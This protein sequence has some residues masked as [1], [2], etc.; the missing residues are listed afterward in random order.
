MAV[1]FIGLLVVLW[2][3]DLHNIV[4]TKMRIDNAGD[5]AALSAARWQGITLNMVGEVNLIQAAL[6]CDKLT[7]L[8]DPL[9]SND[10]QQLQMDVE[11]VADLRSRLSLN[12]PLMGYIAAQ[13][14]AF[15]NLKEKDD[16]NR[17]QD[18][19]SW[20]AERA[21]DFQ[22]AGAYFGGTVE[23]PYDGAWE[24]Y[25]NLLASIAGNKMVAECANPEFFLYY[26]TGDHILLDP[27]FYQ[28][29]AAGQWCYFKDGEARSLIESYE[30]YSDWAP[31]PP[32]RNRPAVNSE[33]FGLDLYERTASLNAVAR[34]MESALTNHYADLDTGDWP[35][36]GQMA[37]HFQNELTTN[38]TVDVSRLGD[39]LSIDFPWHVY[40]TGKWLGSP[41]PT[42][43]D[44][45]FEE[46]QQILPE[47]D[48]R[49]ADAVVDCYINAENITPNMQVDSDWIYWH[50]AAKPFGYLEDPDQSG[51]R[52]TP[53]YFGV[54]LPA[55]DD[56]RLIHTDLSSSPF[57]MIPPGVYEHF[58]KHLPEY[59]QNGLSGI[60][61]NT[62]W[63]CRMLR[64]WEDASFREEGVRWLEQH[65]QE[66]DSGKAC[67][68]PPPSYHGG[69][70]SS[71][72]AM[73]RG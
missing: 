46:G 67:A 22:T 66:I 68:P 65:Q 45:P 54:V 31:L 14:A 20:L 47:Y 2:N 52:R 11:E 44:F 57:G 7:G 49:G 70:G 59:E 15:M 63:Y 62:D 53:V 43:P 64:K 56:A 16:R 19:S 28:A 35:L 33:Y 42:Y 26:S 38:Y 6:V 61:G 10:V 37:K 39:M 23:A 55:F 24:E 9:S 71:G 41:W 5:A 29:V 12:G 4:S 60:E 69:G 27:E 1:L 48:Y 40:S 34:G 58:Y 25:G 8:P 30:S 13:S 21:Q 51:L 50:A 17:E 73:G 18:F 3:Y 72:G 36:A 32:L